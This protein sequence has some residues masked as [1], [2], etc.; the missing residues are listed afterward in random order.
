MS[1]THSRVGS[2]D[3]NHDQV[4]EWYVQMGCT[5]ADVHHVPRFVD[6][7]VGACG[8][9]DLVEVKTEDG[10]PSPRQK[11][12]ARDWRGSRPVQIRTLDD[13]IGHVRSMRLRASGRAA[14]LEQNHGNA[15]ADFVG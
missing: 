3:A 9:T 15:A 11:T 2:K 8:V 6:W 12:F 5:A 10:Q 7:V 1:F 13:V 4:G 14:I